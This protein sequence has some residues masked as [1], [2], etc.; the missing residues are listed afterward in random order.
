ML[1]LLTIK[2]F[3]LIESLEQAFDEGFTIITGETGAGK[4]ILLGALG[5]LQGKRAD[6]ASLKNKE[7]KCI[8]EGHFNLVNYNLEEVFDSLS[9][10]YEEITIIRREILP[11]GKSRAFVN[12]SPVNLSDLQVLSSYLIDI[13]SQHQTGELSDENY[14]LQIIDIIADNHSLL[15]EYSTTLKEYK[16]RVN[17]LAD[18][19]EL[20]SSLV[21]EQDYNNFLLQELEEANLTS[22]NQVVLE[23]E[24]E[25]LNN[26][27]HVRE[28][29]T[30][31]SSLFTEEQ[32]GVISNLR[33]IRTLLQKI[34][35]LDA[36][37][38]ELTDRVISVDIEVSDIANDLESLIES[39]ISD[40]EQMT[41]INERLQLL[42]ALQ[43]K[44]Q[45][46]TVEELLKIEE[47]LSS[48]VFK[49]NSLEEQIEKAQK[50]IK[51]LED[52]LSVLAN[53]ISTARKD[54]IPSL[55][56]QLIDILSLVGMPA[57][58][59]RFKFIEAA[60]FLSNGK[61][62]IQLM[63]SANKG[64]DFGLLK[65]VASGGEMSRI[66]LAIKSVLAVYSNLPTIIFDE[67]DTG[68]SGEVADKMGNIM[69]DMSSKMQVFAITHLPQI[70]CKGNTHFK[71][72]KSEDKGG[73]ISQLVELKDD[74][75]VNEI[76]QM[77]SGADISESAILHA[78]E[79]LQK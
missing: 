53:N 55:Q 50:D 42:Y 41:L 10:D 65:K 26:V 58:R 68:V 27:E 44:H 52:R 22:L 47:E 14:Q 54:V 60:H 43:K 45:V 21:K 76:A 70:A 6:L 18:Y 24:Y 29:F 2:N 56:K 39:V 19:I 57:S 3:A 20:Q 23:Q 25:K 33:E 61:D 51:R 48:K 46:S 1:S 38:K 28:S 9:V 71:V 31:A 67:I 77:L 64:S 72:F 69:R 4:S 12:D 34:S 75:R 73:T 16:Q 59:F 49:A 8:V 36:E 11:S 63:F 40:P 7:E 62:Q 66:M 37:Y 74:K 15:E 17:E 13:H 5:L 30:H 79:L 78:K 32:V 35:G